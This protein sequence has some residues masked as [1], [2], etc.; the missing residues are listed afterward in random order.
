VSDGFS[1]DESDD[2]RDPADDGD[3]RDG[4]ERDA[5]EE[6]PAGLGAGPT[7]ASG[8]P[9]AGARSPRLVR[10]G[11]VDTVLPL[12]RVADQPAITP[13]MTAVFGG[14]FG[15]ATVASVFAL[16]IQVFPVRD[17]RSRA[18]AAVSAP[19]A[20]PAPAAGPATRPARKRVRTL[21]PGPWRVASLKGSQLLVSG[22]MKRRSFIKALGEADVPKAEVYRILKALD[23]IARLDRPGNRDRFTVAMKRGTKQVVAF[24][25][26]VG[27]TEIYQAR[28]DAAGLLQGTRLDLKVRS[29]EYAGSF[30]LTKDFVKS[31]EHGGFEPGLSEVV[32]EAFNGRTSSEA[33]AEGGSVKI[34]AVEVTALGA[35]VRYERLRALEYR[36]PDP[37]QAPLRAYWFQ[38]ETVQ[39]YVDDKGRRPSNHGWRSPIPGAPVTSNFNPKRLHPVLKQVMAHNGTDYGAPAGTPVHAAYRGTVALAGMH[40]ASGNLVLIDHPGGIQTGYAHLLRFAPGIEQGAKVGTR[41]LIGYVGSTG[42]STGPHLHFSARRDGR[43]F[44]PLALDLDA[45]QLLPVEER[46]RFL[47]QKAALDRALEAIALPE[48]PAPEPVA[49]SA[50]AEPPDEAAGTPEAAGGA[51]AEEQGGAPPAAA[52]SANKPTKHAEARDGGDDLVGEDLAGDIE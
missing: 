22:E 45:L 50:P 14:L 21:L 24:E 10:P 37:A 43:F 4:D 1:V 52:P 35:F 5:A 16:L 19:S 17:E 46:S 41:Q 23:G 40:G 47:E 39:G 38:G 9:P 25:Y 11:A 31:Y 6:E 49:A 28:A 2:E 36:P 33:F 8:T 20:S 42:R 34:V 27:P 29:E 13:R 12:S 15:L 3:E 44:D 26:A 18:V 7:R 51:A 48:P 32:N 30:Y